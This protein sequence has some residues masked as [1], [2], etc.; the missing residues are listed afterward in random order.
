[1]IGPLAGRGKS[2]IL[3]TS[4]KRKRA[5]LA[6]IP[7]RNSRPKVIASDGQGGFL[8]PRPTAWLGPEQEAVSRLRFTSSDDTSYR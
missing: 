1:M 8:L 3:T 2:F 7:P 5:L 4:V 6:S